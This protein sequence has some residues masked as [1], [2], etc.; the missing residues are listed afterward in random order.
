[1]TYQEYR[2]NAERLCKATLSALQKGYIGDNSRTTWTTV[3][4]T[5]GGNLQTQTSGLLYPEDFLTRYGDCYP[6]MIPWSVC[7]FIPYTPIEGDDAFSEVVWWQWWKEK[8]LER[9]NYTKTK[10]TPLFANYAQ[11]FEDF[12][13]KSET[14]SED[15]RHMDYPAPGGSLETAYITGGSD[16]KGTRTRTWKGSDNPD[17]LIKL[18]EFANIVEGYWKNFDCIFTY[19]GNL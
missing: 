12:V 17:R 9:F 15:Y 4:Q 7:Q 6:V 11:L 3:L 16:N 14:I 8:L 13:D 5:L 1:M 10:Y 2:E 19:G 18:N